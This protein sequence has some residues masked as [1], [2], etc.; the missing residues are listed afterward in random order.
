MPTRP[1]LGTG[2]WGEW[3]TTAPKQEAEVQ[4]SLAKVPGPT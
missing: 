2:E 3:H 4:A 1:Q